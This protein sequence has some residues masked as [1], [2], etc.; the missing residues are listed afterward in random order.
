MT[1]SEPK[2]NRGKRSIALD[3]VT[4]ATLQEHRQRQRSERLL[5]GGAYTDLDLVFA[6][7][8]G[9]P[10]HPDYISQLFDRTVKR[11]ELPRIRLHDLRH[12]HATL[13]LAAGVPTK[14]MSDRLGHAT[15]SFTEDIYMHAVPA[16]EERAAADV[17]DLI[18]SNAETPEHP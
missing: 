12:T 1:T 2:T 11:L 10:L 8:D 7:E 15:T 16:M 18:F 4:V 14:V 5:A 6:R 3:P 9:Q 17:A 13:G